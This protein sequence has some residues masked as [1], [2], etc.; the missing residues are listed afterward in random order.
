M[1]APRANSRE[2]NS[3]PTGAPLSPEKSR[4]H[5][6]ESSLTRVLPT[7][8]AFSD[9]PTCARFWYGHAPTSPGRRF[10]EA[11]LQELRSFRAR[12]PVSGLMASRLP[13][14]RP[15][16]TPDDH[17]PGFLNLPRPP[18]V[19]TVDDV[20]QEYQPVLHRLRLSASAQAQ[21]NPEQIS[22]TQE[23][24]GIRRRGFSPLSS[25]TPAFSLP[26]APQ[27]ASH[28]FTASG[29]LPYHSTQA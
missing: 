16:V 7:A 12:H 21:T 9:L 13:T 6:A 8:L 18:S 28:R 20:V 17:R 3:R 22:F 15:Q 24:L 14:G 10:S 5:F 27:T 2:R 29:T 26:D 1:R 11:W 25:T 19:I 4:G 23:P